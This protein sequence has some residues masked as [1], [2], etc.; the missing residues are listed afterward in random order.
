MSHILV[1]VINI[2]PNSFQW[3]K[4][5]TFS[6]H[7]NLLVK[8]YNNE[9]FSFRIMPAS[10]IPKLLF[11]ILACHRWWLAETWISKE[12]VEHVENIKVAD[13]IGNSIRQPFH[14][15]RT[16]NQFLEKIFHMSI[17]GDD[18]STRIRD[19]IIF[20]YGGSPKIADATKYWINFFYHPR[21]LRIKLGA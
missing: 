17:N 14:F 11:S 12:I 2:K 21:N 20:Q 5:S 13:V 10:S 15:N 8:L 3:T 1:K 9:V 6:Q 19:V 16:K 18:L 4:L 7:C